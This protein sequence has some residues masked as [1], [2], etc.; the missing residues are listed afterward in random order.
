MGYTIHIHVHF[1]ILVDLLVS[2][3]PVAY[4]SIRLSVL[5]S[6]LV[7]L[8]LMSNLILEPLRQL[9]PWELFHVSLFVILHLYIKSNSVLKH[10]PEVASFILQ[11]FSISVSQRVF[12]FYFLIKEFLFLSDTKNVV[13]FDNLGFSKPS[14]AN[15]I[16]VNSYHTVV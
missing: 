11:L 1:S 7:H 4:R 3:S 5:E 8:F 16:L 6:L 14:L 12:S 9:A 15:I 13:I 10:Q 2:S